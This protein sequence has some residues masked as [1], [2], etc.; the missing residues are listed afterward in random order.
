MKPPLPRTLSAVPQILHA[1]LEIAKAIR[2]LAGPDHDELLRQ[3]R[4]EIA[5]IRRDL[6]ALARGVRKL[7]EELPAL[8]MAEL[9][10][11]LKKYSPDQLRVPAGN[12]GGGQWMS[13]G[14]NGPANDSRVVS[15]VTPDNTWIPGAQYA[16]NT[17]RGG[18]SIL[19]GGNWL[20]PTPAQAARLT[21]AE[22]QARDALARVRNFD[23]YWQPTPGLYATVEG[24]ISDL[25]AQAQEA[26]A[27]LDELASV[28][29]GP[30]PFAGNSI[31]ARG[32]GRNFSA[33]ER[34][35]NNENGDESGCHTCGIKDPGTRLGNYVLDH[36]PPSAL[37]VFGVEQRLYPQCLS[38][39]LRQGL[40][41]IRYLR[42]KR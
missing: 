4:A 41:M 39:S 15:D 2:T 29:I 17:R 40:W 35:E 18:G 6:D 22:A 30:G 21:V 13:D 23:P 31:P 11:A 24:K 25:Q 26:R 10:A 32:P 33:A 1:Q 19:I 36:Q 37:N 12:S 9:R 5:A 7:G 38:C 27:R 20:D 3:R 8:V 34:A 16:Q 14:G 28:G 42:D